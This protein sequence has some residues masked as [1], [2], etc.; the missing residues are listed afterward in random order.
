MDTH[1][2]ILEYERAVKERDE[3][4]ALYEQ[5]R[6]SI[7]ALVQGDLEALDAEMAPYLQGYANVASDYEK[8]A[9]EQ[10]LAL[11]QTVDGEKTRFVYSKGKTTW[12]GQKLQ[13]MEAIIPEIGKAKKVGEPS[14]A[15]K[16]RGQHDSANKA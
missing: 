5:R 16:K 13:G 2:L 12:D 1:E 14:V 10:V 6:A 11:G 9:R 15:I 3:M 7:L 4:Q 8:L